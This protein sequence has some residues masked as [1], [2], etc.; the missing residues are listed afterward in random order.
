[1]S[2]EDRRKEYRTTID[3]ITTPFLGSRNTD[4]SC[5]EYEIVDISRYGLQM[6]VSVGEGSSYLNTDDAISLHVGFEWDGTFFDRGTVIWLAKGVEKETRIC[7]VRA[8]F[9][10]PFPYELWFSADT[11]DVQI[12]SSGYESGNELFFAVLNRCVAMKRRISRA[13]FSISDPTSGRPEE[14][15]QAAHYW[16]VRTDQE[17][18]RLNE[19]LCFY[20]TRAATA[21]DEPVGRAILLDELKQLLKSDIH[22]ALSRVRGARRSSDSSVGQLRELE[23]GIRSSYNTIVLLRACYLSYIYKTA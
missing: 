12:G 9:E 20:F 19:Y 1:M 18:R 23:S 16:Q 11:C 21:S 7:G 14:L 10:L 17:S 5:F 4:G 2:L 8:E 3:M 13:L 6:A 15:R 22:C